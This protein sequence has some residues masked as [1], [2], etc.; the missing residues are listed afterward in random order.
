VTP[1]AVV[2][3]LVSGNRWQLP[4]GEAYTGTLAQA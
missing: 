2:I 3:P 1:F 4:V